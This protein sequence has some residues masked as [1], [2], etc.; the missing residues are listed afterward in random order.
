[1]PLYSL[2]SAIHGSI[3]CLLL[4]LVS[5]HS[6]CRFD[7]SSTQCHPTPIS[8]PRS[9]SQAYAEMKTFIIP[10]KK[11][12]HERIQT[13]KFTKEHKKVFTTKLTKNFNHEI[14]ERTRKGINAK[15]TKVFEKHEYNTGFVCGSFMVMAY[16]IFLSDSNPFWL[17]KL[18]SNPKQ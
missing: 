7:I 8:L 5:T 17:P 18:I 2:C 11:F 9:G 15:F 10:R 14:H 13:T 6:S 12:N 4:S 16:K 3:L 1:M